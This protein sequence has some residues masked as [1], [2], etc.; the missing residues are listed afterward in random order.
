MDIET[1]QINGCKKLYAEVFQGITGRIPL[2]ITPPCGAEPD[3]KELVLHTEAAMAQVAAARQPKVEAKSD[4]IPTV[5]FGW[6]QCIAVPSLFGAEPFYPA[7]SEPIIEPIF[8]SMEGAVAAGTPELAGPIIDQMFNSLQTAL[9]HL[10]AGFALSFPPS[11]SPFDLAQLLLPADEFM[12]SLIYEPDAT[13]Q[14]LNNLTDLCLELTDQVR[15]QLAGTT[16]E[17]ITNRGTSFHG[18]RLPS[19]SIV[20]LSPDLIRAFVLPILNRYS[21]RYGN[22]MIHYCSKPAPSGHILP[23][24]CECAAVKA[25]DTWQGPDAFIGDDINVRLQSK[26]ALLFDVDL[27]TEEKMDNFLTWEPIRNVAR[28][29]GRGLVI[30]TTAPSIEAAHEIYSMWQKKTAAIKMIRGLLK[31]T[32]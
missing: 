1:E 23:V 28:K 19:D 15:S 14:F 12:V 9:K 30:E 21:D 25:V 31:C 27:T 24:L 20:N 17:H 16:S 11:A 3:K 8:S 5:N 26:T 2:I 4:W 32:S 6:Y 22:L 10:P 13:M 7:G 29:N 18:H